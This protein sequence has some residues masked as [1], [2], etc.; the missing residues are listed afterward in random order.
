MS[1]RDH[2]DEW[3]RLRGEGIGI[4]EIGARYG[5]SGARVQQITGKM[6]PLP[7]TK[8]VKSEPVAARSIRAD[9]PWWTVPD[10]ELIR[11]AHEARDEIRANW[12]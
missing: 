9:R 5:F 3:L 11:L 2:R 1:A 4:R 12:P 6:V 8:V 10:S 7:R